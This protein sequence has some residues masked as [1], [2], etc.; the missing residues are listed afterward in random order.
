MLTFCQSHFTKHCKGSQYLAILQYLLVFLTLNP[1]YLQLI[2]FYRAKKTDIA[3]ASR[4]ANTCIKKLSHRHKSAHKIPS[5]V[6]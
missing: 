6:L 1:A 2:S 3:P 4:S 5:S